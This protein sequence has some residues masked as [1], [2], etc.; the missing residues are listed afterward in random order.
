[1]A[2]KTKLDSNATELRFCEEIS[3]KTLNGDANDI[4][5]QLEPNSYNDFGGEISTTP[6]RP[7]DS[8]RQQKKG[9]TTDLDANGGFETDLTQT[10]LQNLLQGYFVADLRR[11]GEETPTAVTGT[12]DLFS[13]A[14]TTGF[15]V[16]DLVFAADF[17]D[18]ANNGLHVVTA[19]VAD[20]TIECLGSSLVTDG[21]PSGTLV[22]VGHQFAAD[23]LNVVVSGDRPVITSDASFDFSTLGLIPGEPVFLG[24]DT[25][26]T[27]FVNAENSGFARVFA[28]EATGLTLDKTE[29]AMVAESLALGETVQ[30]FFG[31]VLKNESDSSLQVRRTYQLER[32]LG[33][34]DD[35]QPTQE[36]AEYI[37]GAMPSEFEMNMATADKIV[38]NLGFVGAD[39]ETIDGPTTLK[40][41]TRPALVEADAFNTSSDIPRINLSVY[42]STNSA[43]TPLFAYVGDMSLTLNNNVTPNKAIGTLGAFEITLGL[44]EV[45]GEMNAYFQNVAG[46]DAVRNN[47]NVTLD[48]H[49][50]KN[51]AG[52]SIDMPLITLGNARP[53][54]AQDESIMLPLSIQ[55]AS[56]SAIDASMNHTMLMVFWDYLPTAA[57]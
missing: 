9:V 18:A 48:V 23:D 36:Q 5:Y 35:S 19:I 55:A 10:N 43:P 14:S 28:A 39:N 57:E 32:K 54:V 40:A 47:S 8:G 6:R 56:G 45:G 38:C 30:I 13:V 4:W 49:M 20:T 24:G 50:V 46:I 33:A 22:V 42:S 37:V 26:A 44:F 1:M 34:P 2:A 31:R 53:E 15:Q 12:T 16:G 52:I 3:Y 25:T 17:D 7:L 51:N 11:K 27:K 21:S 29:Q 41:G